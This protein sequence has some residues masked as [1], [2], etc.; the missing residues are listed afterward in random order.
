MIVWIFQT[1]E[2]LHIDS[3]NPR[4]MRAMN[5]SDKQKGVGLSLFG[6]L[7]ITP[8]SLFIR[9]INIPSWELLFYRG[10]IPSIFLLLGLIIYYKKNFFKFFYN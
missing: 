3:E 1:G 10:L 6:V 2:P 5:L 7:I 9:L 4:P 8:D